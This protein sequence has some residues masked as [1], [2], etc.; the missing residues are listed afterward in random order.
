VN[1]LVSIVIPSFGGAERLPQVI[2][3]LASQQTSLAWEAVVVLDGT[4][5][6]SREVLDGLDAPF[7]R[8]LDLP[9]NRGRAAALNAGCHAATGELLIRCDDDLVPR[10]DFVEGHARWHQEQE[11][12]GV[13]GLCLNALPPTPYAEVWGWGAD[14]TQRRAAYAGHPGARWRLWAGNCSVRRTLH[15]EIGGYDESFRAYGWED[16]EYGYRLHLAGAAFVLDPALETPHRVAAITTAI[17]CERAFRSGQARARFARKHQVDPVV[18]LPDPTIRQLVWHGLVGAASLGTTA[19]QYRRGGDVVD[20]LLSYLPR[21]A[22]RRLVGLSI[23]AA[24]A[25][26]FRHHGIEEPIHTP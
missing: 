12:R 20:G 9:E 3:A 2:G 17:R 15:E 19:N 5:D 26:G 16:V 21:N 11:R 22:G 18:S 4:P 6:R 10:P 1:P 8:V 13:I 23:E 7:L 14:E 25:A 24:A